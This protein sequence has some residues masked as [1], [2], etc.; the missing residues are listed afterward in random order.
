MRLPYLL[1]VALAASLA[2]LSP[3]ACGTSSPASSPSPDG[4]GSDAAA[5]PETSTDATDSAPDVPVDTPPDVDNGAPSTNYPAP[6]PAL[7]QLVNNAN[8]P[9]LTSPKVYLVFYAGDPNV[10]PLQDFA[11]KMVASTFWATTTHEYGVG[12]LA[13]GGTITL[14]AT[15]TAPTS[16]ASTDIQTWVAAQI[17]QGTFGTPDPE[18]IYTIVYPQGTTITQPNPVSSLLASPQSCVDFG[19]Y[20]D[21]TTPA[22]GGVAGNFAYAVIPTCTTSVD[23]L[24]AVISH[25]WVEASTDPFLTSGGTFTL[26]GGPNAAFYSADKSHLVWD[27]LGGGEAGDM[28]EPESPAVYITP[29]DIG[30]QVQRTWSNLQA[31]GSH[32]PCAPD[33]AGAFFDSA[34]VLTE[35]VTFSSSITGTITSQGI[36]IPVGQSKTI[37]VDLFSD[38]DTGGPWTVS[39]DDV[40]FKY[41]GSYG[42]PQ[43][44]SFAW[45]RTQGVNG[46]KLHLTVTVTQASIIAGAHA[47]MITSTNG[48]RQAVW[49]GLVVE[50]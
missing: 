42:I 49:P 40:L 8:G 47:F 12:P 19:G 38:G 3:L 25:E 13:Y 22:D 9:I 14:P 44:L 1:T 10:A 26:S 32:D 11:Q 31:Q 21:N 27:L 43:S 17:Q 28:C 50:Q 20:H 30:Y 37:E 4:G 33:I 24:T 5:G 35:T 39:A 15:E 45:D 34:P 46:E 7:P 6:H 29:S 23:D 18:A 48:T 36:T 16:I 41:Y 2:A